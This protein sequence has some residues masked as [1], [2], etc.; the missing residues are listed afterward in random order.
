MEGLRERL[1]NASARKEKLRVGP[2]MLA[3]LLAA[4]AAFPG[5]E[6][7]EIVRMALRWSARLKLL[8]VASGEKSADATTGGR[9]LNLTL[10][11]E[12][13]A[14][15]DEMRLAIDRYLT[16][17]EPFPKPDAKLVELDLKLAGIER[18]RLELKLDPS[19]SAQRMKELATI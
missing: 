17:H 14:T 10:Y 19:G 11:G 18:R 1:K 13:E 7:N 16:A 5:C 3:R 9:V 6:L 15:E 12:P 8:H 2:K 4:K